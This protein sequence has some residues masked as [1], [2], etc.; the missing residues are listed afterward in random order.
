MLDELKEIILYNQ[1]AE[2][3]ALG[4]FCK[5]KVVMFVYPSNRNKVF[6]DILKE[7]DNLRVNKIAVSTDS[8]DEN[9]NISGIYGLK[10]DILSDSSRVLSKRL[11]VLTTDR[12]GREIF[13]PTI[14]F[15]IDGKLEKKN[16]IYDMDDLTS[17]LNSIEDHL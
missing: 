7:L 3:V 6:I 11:G 8:I 15:F 9:L 14:Y 1:R 16:T 2:A 13:V 17:F 5:G 10:L 12:A 4:K